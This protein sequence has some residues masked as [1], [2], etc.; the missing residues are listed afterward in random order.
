MRALFFDQP[1]HDLVL[2]LEFVIDD[3]NLELLKW[4][5]ANTDLLGTGT[6]ILGLFDHATKTGKTV[7]Q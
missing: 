7:D 6:H 2:D 3:D 5:D 1:H 4:L